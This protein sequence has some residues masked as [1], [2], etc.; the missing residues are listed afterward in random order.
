MQGFA[1][2][3]VAGFLAAGLPAPA[4]SVSALTD[5]RSEV[6]FLVGVPGASRSIAAGFFNPGAWAIQRHGGVFFGWDDERGSDLE[7][8]AGMVS[9]RY[10]G[11]GMRRFSSLSQSGAETHVNDY[12][13]GFS[14][15]NR[16]STWGLSYGW[17]GGD[18]EAS[19]RHE[20]LT[21]GTVSRLRAASLGMVG[22][23]DLE[24]SDYVL[25]GDVGIRPFGP[26]L[27]LFAD[28]DYE[29]GE[30][31]EDI[32]S[33]YGA[34]VHVIPGL[35][36]AGKVRSTGEFSLRVN[37]SPGRYSTL[38]ARPH[39]DDGGD[40]NSSTYAVELAGPVPSLGHGRVGRGRA[41][42]ELPL[43]G[44]M[45]HQRYRFFDPSRT[46]LGTLSKLDTWSDDPTVGGV[47]LNLSGM[48]IGAE[49]LWELRSQL[50]GFRARGK[51]VVVYGDEL[52]LY[53][54]M[55]ASVAD[56]IWMDPLGGLD[57]LG[58]TLGRTY[59]RHAL[60][61]LGVGVDEW[62][63]FTYKSAFEGWSRDSM[64]EPDREQLQMLVDD[65]YDHIAHA[66]AASRGLTRA[67]WDALVDSVG[68]FRPREAQAAGL[69]DSIGG[70]ERARESARRG[71]RR[72]TGDTEATALGRIHGDPI[73]GP[74]E[75]GE[76]VRIAV[77][78]A[79]GPC[80]MDTGIR[81]R[82]LSSAIK[83]ARED[84]SVKALVLRADSPGGDPL[85]SDLV[86]RE[87]RAAAK[88]KPVIVSQGRVAASGGYWI[89]M[90]A[91]TIVASP[92]TIT[93]SIGVIAGFMWNKELG[94]KIGLDYDH[95]KRGAHAD[96]GQGFVIPYLNVRVPD[97]PVTPD[98][99]AHAEKVIRSLY[100]EFVAGVA[101]GRGMTP[102][103]V[104]AIAQGRVWSGTR[105]RTNGLVD[106]LG[107]LWRSIE[108]AKQA[109]GIPASRAVTLA[110]AP[111]RGFIDM[112][113]LRPRL[114]GVDSEAV[115]GSALAASAVA[116]G[117][118]FTAAEKDYLEALARSRGK[119]LL[120]L[121][122]LEIQD[123]GPQP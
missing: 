33:G 38:S 44:R 113:A 123:G 4:A 69:V 111:D 96:L 2:L 15:G 104:E 16:T 10:L 110:E 57:L 55:L 68:A 70:F 97:R 29:S 91:D 14:G 76:P 102:A 78:Y 67:K 90:A 48:R 62:R 35:A 95:V 3:V 66:V 8:Y 25:Q 7:S 122:P 85:P 24:R 93:G 34:E 117:S 39:L 22:I 63:F 56:E 36:L 112:A 84:R 42:P 74:E 1:R 65:A 105:G 59:M 116:A 30:S 58:L 81:G 17:G 46:L 100:D 41:F 79:I 5:Y 21:V 106:E 45:T 23:W 43:R 114:L 73:W 115:E 11:F 51:K 40:R 77:L 28:A 37:L 27:T 109:A 121:E 94:Q 64:S 52:N 47:V 54:Y 88:V 103:D 13:L 87:L 71:A 12:T 18:L 92:L 19:P 120:W 80:E 118:P 31:F 60:D 20:R 50:A 89:S 99:R 101:K 98:E 32:R 53:A 83:R 86:A 75:W 108:I 82:V 6:D 9:L 49:M 72:T 61:K 26:R 107:G 119:P